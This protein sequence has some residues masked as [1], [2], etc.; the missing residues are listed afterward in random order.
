M[1]GLCE[2]GSEP[3]GSL[4]ANNVRVGFRGWCTWCVDKL[5]GFY[6]VV[7]VLVADVSTALKMT[8]TQR[9]KRQPPTPRQRGRQ[10]EGSRESLEESG[11]QL[12]VSYYTE[13]AWTDM[14]FFR[15]FP[16]HLSSLSPSLQ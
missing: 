8:T 10:G 2:S 9:S 14:V 4:K 1:A 11:E 6:R 5:Q 15:G 3:Q 16:L 12:T 7:L 13:P